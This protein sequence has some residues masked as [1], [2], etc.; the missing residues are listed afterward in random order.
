L[1]RRTHDDVLELQIGP[2]AYRLVAHDD[3]AGRRLAELRAAADCEPP[4]PGTLTRTVHLLEMRLSGDEYRTMNAHRLP[5]RLR[6]S[7]RGSAHA[8]DLPR[9]DWRLAADE[10]GVL[11]WWHDGC[12]AAFLTLD[13]VPHVDEARLLF[14][15]TLVVRDV[16]AAGGAVAH[17]ALARRSSQAVAMTAPPDG[18]K[19]TAAAR[20]QSPWMAL[21]DDACLVWFDAGR[22][23]ASAL[24]TWGVAIGASPQPAA[25]PVWRLH[26]VVDLTAVMVLEKARRDRIESLAEI[27]ALR[28]LY[29]AFSEH[30]SVCDERR[31]LR[32]HL[33]AVAARLAESLPVFRLE[34]TLTGRFRPLIE[35]A[36]SA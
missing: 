4:A 3:A 14:P 10:T 13:T 2:L 17:A 31:D 35:R 27:D 20:L 22:I 18:G 19:S 1:T 32:D 16:T 12:D 24:P 30:P 15:W 29:R 36:L 9:N 21:A 26:D 11:T 33:F 6:L 23:R 7:T 34:L 5:E 8:G 25:I 28:V